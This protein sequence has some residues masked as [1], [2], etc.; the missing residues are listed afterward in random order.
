MKV[1][2]IN[3]FLYPKGGAEI[4]TLT[5]GN[6]LS[7]KGHEVFYWGMD[8]PENP[9]YPY[10]EH[11][12][13]YIDFNKHMNILQKFR[14]MLKMWYSL[15]SKR[16]IEKLIKIINPD[17]VHL[18]NIHHH[19]S[20]SIL[21]SLTKRNI[22]VV[23]TLRDYKIVCPYYYLMRPDGVICEKCKGGKY[24]F[25]FLGKCTKGSFSRS[26]I[27]TIEMYIHHKILHIFDKVDLF[28]SPSLFLKN[29]LREMGFTKG[30][31]CLPNFVDLANYS[32]QYRWKERSVVYFGRLSREKGLATL[33]EAVKGLNI[34]LKII[35]DGPIKQQLEQKVSSERINN[36]VFM[37]YKSGEELKKE[38]K[39][40]I[41]TILPSECY[42]TFGRTVVE[43][44][45]LGKPVIGARIGAIPELIKDNETGLTFEPGN[46]EDLKNKIKYL[47]ENADLIIKMGEK[48][49]NFAEKNFNA[50]SHYEEL[51]KIYNK[52]LK[53]NI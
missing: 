11:F 7:K 13:P 44:F 4:S 5:T 6:L 31:T 38:I 21:D 9:D 41:V 42:E 25:C 50:Q 51:I 20:P 26:L 2:L 19:L 46:F 8:H 47:T 1:L 22:P 34:T 30:I 35:G 40:S 43:S 14:V 10:K 3:K 49:R 48:A 17:I 33:L 53:H 39:N 52:A 23:M 24:Y 45:A 29:K 16:K 36:V 12:V 28:I 37:G 15:E 27:N 32:P 18:N